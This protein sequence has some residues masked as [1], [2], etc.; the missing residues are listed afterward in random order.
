[1]A[2]AAKEDKTMLFLTKNQ[3]VKNIQ[4]KSLLR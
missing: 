4:N 1:L 2:G 3:R